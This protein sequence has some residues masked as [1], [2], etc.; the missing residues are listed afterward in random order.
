MG[1]FLKKQ[2]ATDPVWARGECWKGPGGT[3]L[4]GKKKQKKT[5]KK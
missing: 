5:K 1:C 4:A 2:R 3:T